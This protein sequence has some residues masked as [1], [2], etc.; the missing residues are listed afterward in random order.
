MRDTVPKGLPSLL[1]CAVLAFA[2][3]FC[4]S[5]TAAAPRSV[6][7]TFA[8]VG[9][10]FQPEVVSY[11]DLGFRTVIRQQYDF[12]CGSAALATLLRYDYGV[13]V[14]ETDV[15]NAMWAKGDQKTIKL[16]GFSL[17]D[18]KHYL[19]ARGLR[20]D[21]Y[22]ITLERFAKAQVPGI[23]V[24]TLNGYK[25]FVVVKGVEEGL[26][27]VG[28]PAIGLHAYSVTDFKKI[29]DGLVFIIHDEA[30][31]QDH[32]EFNSP[33]EWALLTRPYWEPVVNQPPAV[34]DLQL[35]DIRQVFQITPFNVANTYVAH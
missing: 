28:D 21:G 5:A 25:H 7:E 4:T 20:S 27:L 23:V 9:G 22:R 11:R 6:V 15:F 3:T 14:D 13:P 26:V 12:S 18:M 31:A 24:V 30:H 19:T 29:W 34:G 32:H 35:E 2:G 16:K 33:K 10:E 1:A 8:A 17:A